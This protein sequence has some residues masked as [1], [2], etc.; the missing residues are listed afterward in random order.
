M[1][2]ISYPVTHLNT[3]QEVQI[4]LNATNYSVVC[5]FMAPNSLKSARRFSNP[6]KER[7]NLCSSRS[8][9]QHVPTT[10]LAVNDAE[11]PFGLNSNL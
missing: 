4:W 1:A 11:I 10:S 5:V 9:Q 3:I 6:K 2:K 8:G 7:F